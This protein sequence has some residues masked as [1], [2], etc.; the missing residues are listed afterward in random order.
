VRELTNEEQ[1]VK[2][3]MEGMFIPAL[4]DV[5]KKANP[6]EYDKWKGNACRQTAVFGTWYL[7]HVLPRYTWTAW[8]GLFD[9]I[10]YGKQVQYNHAWIIGRLAAGNLRV[11]VDMSRQ[12]HERLFIPVESNAYPKNHPEYLNT[13]ILERYPIDMQTSMSEDEYYTKLPS[14][15]VY[16]M[17]V[18]RMEHYR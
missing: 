3:V 14:L 4:H 16:A 18:K 1:R 8:D 12:H 2:V 7:R 5:L 10:V 6:A 17:I 15:T 11:L 9:D 13:K